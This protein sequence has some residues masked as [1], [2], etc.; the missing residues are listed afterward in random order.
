MP[1]VAF[2]LMAAESAR[3]IFVAQELVEGSILMSDISFRRRLPLSLFG[4][5]SDLEL[6]LNAQAAEQ[7]NSFSFNILYLLHGQ[8]DSSERVCSGSFRWTA[9]LSSGTGSFARRFSRDHDPWLLELSQALGSHL[10]HVY[11][12]QP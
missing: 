7:A 12:P 11:E 9:A 3:Q 8:N 6:H 10:L 2:V 4:A 5:N 1:A